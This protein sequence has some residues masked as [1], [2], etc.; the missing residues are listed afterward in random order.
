MKKLMTAAAA[1]VLFAGMGVGGANAATTLTDNQLDHVTA[2]F[3][4]NVPIAVAHGTASAFAG[5]VATQQVA[6][7][8]PFTAAAESI[9]E[10]SGV[11]LH[12]SGTA[13]AAIIF[14]A[15]H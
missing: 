15:G 10:A 3:V 12:V 7:V 8:T 13:A 2:G 5:T 1:F 4:I 14:A 6:E 11:G 9:S